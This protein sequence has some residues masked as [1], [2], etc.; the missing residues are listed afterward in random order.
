MT[1]SASVYI[2]ATQRHGKPSKKK[3]PILNNVLSILAKNVD[4]TDFAQVRDHMMYCTMF[5][6]FG[7]VSECTGFGD[8]DIWLEKVNGEWVL[9][10]FIEKS[11]TDQERRGHTVLMGEGSTQ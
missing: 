2:R 7:R 8:D 1:P 3:L 6:S 9:V 10:G 5:K 11:K 4:Q